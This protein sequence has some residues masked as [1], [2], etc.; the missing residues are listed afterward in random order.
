LSFNGLLLTHRELAAQVPFIYFYS[1]PETGAQVAQ[2]GHAVSG[3]PLLKEMFPGDS[4]DYLL[5]LERE[6]QASHFAI[7]RY[8]AYEKQ[9]F[10]GVL[11]VGILS[12][13]RNCEQSIAINENHVT[14]V[15]PC[16]QQADSYI[17]LRNALRNTPIKPIATAEPPKNPAQR[18]AKLLPAGSAIVFDGFTHYGQSTF[19]FDSAEV[20]N[21]GS[22]DADLGV[23]NPSHGEQASFFLMNNHCPYCDPTKPTQDSA[24]AGIID[25]HT[26][27]FDTVEEAPATNYVATYFN[28]EEAHVYCVRTRDGKH[29]AKIKVTDIGK[30]RIAF[31]WVYQPDGTRLL[32]ANR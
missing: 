7:H 29:F 24:D 28:P 15:K 6:W 22:T 27:N 8:C 23:S 21:W 9:A 11:V 3:D 18:P 19:I 10:N 26:R 30:D 5:N 14:I 12:G 4:N 31:D 1:T 16:D 2:L 17:A 20:S 25:M 13:T 32:T